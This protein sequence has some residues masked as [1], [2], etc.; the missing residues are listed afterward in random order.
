MNQAL[1][2]AFDSAA[3]FLRIIERGETGAIPEVELEDHLEKN[4]AL[5]HFWTGENGISKIEDSL[6]LNEKNFKNW[7][8]E[9]QYRIKL[10]LRED[11]GKNASITKDDILGKMLLKPELKSIY[12]EFQNEIH[13]L[14]G[15]IRI[16]KSLIESID[17]RGFHLSTILKRYDK[18]LIKS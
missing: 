10:Q 4:A 16:L 17:K 6:E 9:E 11:W 13:N 12:V 8:A 3:R 5:Y 14:N 7:L 1:K 18:G 15:D 2:D